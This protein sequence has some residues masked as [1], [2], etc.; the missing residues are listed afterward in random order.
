MT[1]RTASLAFLIASTVFVGL[2]AGASARASLAM[3]EDRVLHLIVEQRSDLDTQP[4]VV[5]YW[6]D[7]QRVLARSVETT[8]LGTLTNATGPNWF[9]QVSPRGRATY[10]ETA[11]GAAPT[12]SVWASLFYLRDA[13]AAGAAQPLAQ[14]SGMIAVRLG[15]RSGAFEMA[16][17]LPLWDAADGTRTEYVYHL[18]EQLPVS[19]FPASFFLDTQ[20]RDVSSTYET[21]TDRVHPLVS[22]AAPRVPH[23]LL[24]RPL[25]RTLVTLNPSDL[26]R[27]Q[28]TYVYGDITVT[29]S[30]LAR[31]PNLVRPGGSPLRTALGDGRLFEEPGR[32]QLMVLDGT[33]AIN[34][35]APDAQSAI[36][37]AAIFSAAR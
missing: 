10:L 34:V 16:S 23:D 9:L 15:S 5:E 4:R 11:A 25:A 37:A 20:G 1:A 30:L 21:T 29:V 17:G 35:H 18:R 14:A 7:E 27:E 33:L 28:V 6:L 32:A 3:T 31:E 19:A 2:I 22:F 36:A 8:A 24:G 13:L 26:T 12:R